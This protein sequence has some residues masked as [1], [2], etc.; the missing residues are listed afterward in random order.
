MNKI[1]KP[2]IELPEVSGADYYNDALHLQRIISQVNRS[3]DLTEIIIFLERFFLIYPMHREL[4]ISIYFDSMAIKGNSRLG[5]EAIRIFVETTERVASIGLDRFNV[6]IVVEQNAFL[7][8]IGEAA[9]QSALTCLYQKLGK[10]KE[11]PILYSATELQM[12]NKGFLPYLKDTFEIIVDP[13]LAYYFESIKSIA[14]FNPFIY[15]FSANQYGHNVNFFADCHTDLISRGISPH[16]FKLKDITIQK[17]MKFLKPYGLSE[18]DQ[19]IVLHLREEGYYDRPQHKY[20]N[21]RPNDFTDAIDYFLKQGFKVVRIGHSKMTPIFERNG[22]IDL[23]RIEKPDEVD[24]F[25]CGKAKLYFGSGSG[26]VCLA[27]NFGV[28]T[29]ETGRIPTGRIR[30]NHFAQSLIFKHKDSGK[31]QNFSDFIEQNVENI[32][33]PIVFE[34]LGWSPCFPSSTDNLRF[35][36]ESLEYLYNGKAYLRNEEY[37]SKRKK[38]HVWGG[39]CSNSLH[40][41]D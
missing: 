28:L 27:A 22:F 6:P 29:C 36:E 14:P 18:T 17:A 10:L 39:L 20:R 40:L 3:T 38:Y 24:I 1:L 19:F 33:A 30:N 13:S 11:K 25:L 37:K 32:Q 9:D 2:N 26:P 21:T 7:S 12:A 16:P 34:N 15:K 35:A 31:T 41:L 23:T 5:H 8:R 4:L